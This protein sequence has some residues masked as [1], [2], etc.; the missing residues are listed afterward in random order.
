MSTAEPA[1]R[2]AAGNPNGRMPLLLPTLRETEAL[3]DPKETLRALLR[4]ASGLTGRRLKN[5]H[6]SPLRVS[7]LIDDFSSL[8]MLPAFQRLEAEVIALA[9]RLSSPNQR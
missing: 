8:R 3:V 7:N 4:E 1:I 6:A 9:S 5:F 2:V